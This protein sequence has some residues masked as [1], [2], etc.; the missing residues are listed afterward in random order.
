MLAIRTIVLSFFLLLF[1]TFSFSQA[2]VFG[3]KYY[4]EYNTSTCLYDCHIIITNGSATHPVYRTQFNANYTI[5]APTGTTVTVAEN[6]LPL[7]NNQWYAGT[8]PIEWNIGA[9]AFN[10]LNSG[11]DYH[12]ISPSLS[13]AGQYNDIAAG[14]TLKIFS[15]SVVGNDQCGTGVRFFENGVDPNV[16]GQDFSC[17]FT[18]GGPNQDFEGLEDEV[19]PTLE[20]PTPT[21]NTDSGIS[22][23]LELNAPS[24]QTG[25]TYAWTGPNNYSSTSEDVNINPAQSADYGTYT[26]TVED[27]LGCQASLDVEVLDPNSASISEVTLGS[28]VINPTFENI[29]VH[30]DIEG[31]DNK[32]STMTIEYRLSGTDTYLPGAMTMRSSSDMMVDGSPLGMNFHAGSAMHLL[33]N[34]SYDIRVTLTDED[35]GTEVVEQT[36]QT[37]EFPKPKPEGQVIYVIPGNGGGDGTIGNPYQGLQYAADNAMP[38]DILEV[39]DGVYDPF[40]LTTSGTEESPITIRSTNL[41]GAVIN[42]GNTNT[43]VVTIGTATDSIGHIILD[44]FEIT[45]GAWG[46]DAQNTQH[47]TV[48][49]NKI[50]DVDFGFYNRR[51]NGWEHN[52]YLTNNEIIGRTS[53]PQLD[54]NIPGERGVDIR[55]NNNVISHNSISDFGDGISTDGPAYESSYSLDIHDN[56]ITR[57]VDDIIEVDGTV[58]NA[59][60]YRNQ[61]LNGRTGVSVAPVLGGPA[62]IFRNEFYNLENSAFKMNNESAGLIILNNSIAKEGR[63]LTSPEGWQNTIFKN[64]AIL[65]SHYIFEEFGLV[66]GSIDDWSHNA[67]LSLRAGTNA[68]PWFKWDDVQYAT[69]TDLQASNGTE[70]NSISTSYADFVDVTIPT[71]YSV[72]ALPS[73]YDFQLTPESSLIDQGEYYDNIFDD[74]S[75]IGLVDMGA[76]ESGSPSPD[77]GTDFTNVCDR[78][79][80]ANRLWNGTKNIGW[81]HPSNWTPCGVPENITTVDIPTNLIDYPFLNSDAVAK[82]LNIL[83]NGKLEITNESTLRLDGVE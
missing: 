30:V 74:I 23:D 15:L 72:E 29:A 8:D 12:P 70:A 67:F 71:D 47:L 53:W 59:R 79:N 52:Q 7:E 32:N 58:S 83:G 44:G 45:N 10:V 82:N 1:S 57:I 42:G 37:K 35:G 18:I 17:G 31:D 6:Y 49:N 26:V 55:G 64:N 81:Y 24:C 25:I 33:P 22:I 5:V 80:L 40:S 66:S 11:V 38:G 2:Q 20:I 14:D 75:S 69:L 21:V 78:I 54:G 77:Y 48:K 27:G 65:S 50:N 3:V 34:A 28:V 41:H 39:A 19:Y 13:P 4:M 68:E 62:Y 76:L 43:G 63:G 56:Y 61:G 9:S 16:N 36:V 73:D 51:E 46:I 60:V